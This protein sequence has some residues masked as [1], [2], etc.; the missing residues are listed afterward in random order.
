MPE[1]GFSAWIQAFGI[2]I[3]FDTGQGAALPG[4]ARKL[5]IP[6]DEARH[7]VLSHG[8]YDHGGGIA[9]AMKQA[10]S[11]IIHLH[12]G[13]VIPRYSIE[14]PGKHRAIGLPAKAIRFLN[15]VPEHRISWT[16][17]AV[18]IGPGIGVTGP[19]PRI[20]SYEMPGNAFYT[21]PAGKSKDMILDD[22]ALWIKTDQGLV[23]CSGCAHSGIINTIEHIMNISGQTRIR[24]VAGGFHLINAD[25]SRIKKTITALEKL[26]PELIAQCHCTGETAC[27]LIRDAFKS[28]Y[29]SC[30]AGSTILLN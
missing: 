3:L 23:V 18:K 16:S 26:S 19:I 24:A 21:D 2:N 14:S 29:H 15:T 28:N 8:H 5:G 27:R 20:N 22:Q 9:W 1:H 13:A 30:K 6:V 12:P 4:N 7:L 11:A 25:R 17:R 10:D